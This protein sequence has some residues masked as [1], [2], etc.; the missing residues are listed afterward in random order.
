MR[1]IRGYQGYY[2][3]IDGRI[4][5]EKSQKFLSLKTKSK[6]YVKV[7]LYNNKGKVKNVRVH[8]MI[9]VAF[10]GDIPSGYQINHKNSIRDDNRLENLELLTH[11]Q[12]LLYGDGIQL[13][14][15][16]QIE[17]VRRGGDSNFAVHCVVTD[18]EK[19]EVI[20]FG[21]RKEFIRYSGMKRSDF[22]N[23]YNAMKRAKTNKII[24]KGKAYIIHE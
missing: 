10:N 2:A 5:S 3:T 4:W 20:K 16:A 14:R 15:I 24:L 8:R 22:Y 9:W 11:R 23:K 13:R 21:T 6:G 7:N 18:I 12:N 1:P 17:K 19:G